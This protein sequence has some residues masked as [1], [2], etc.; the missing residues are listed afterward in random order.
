MALYDSFSYS[1]GLALKTNVVYLP[2]T[3]KIF[4]FS[5]FKLSVTYQLPKRS[6]SKLSRGNDD[7]CRAAENLCFFALFLYFVLG[8]LFSSIWSLDSLVILF[9][10]I[11]ELTGLC[12]P[13]AL[14]LRCHGDELPFFKC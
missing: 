11:R 1:A 2:Y 14:L 10:V 4:T 8:L 6:G 7:I 5:N 12:I 9:Y 13:V 3:R